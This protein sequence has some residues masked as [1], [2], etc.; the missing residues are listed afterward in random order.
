[1]TRESQVMELQH[2]V[3]QLEREN[4]RLQD[5]RTY[6]VERFVEVPPPDYRKLQIRCHE[7]SEEIHDL[8]N[9]CKI[10]EHVL[11]YGEIS[12]MPQIIREYKSMS[13]FY[14]QQLAK[15]IEFYRLSSCERSE[16]LNFLEYL[17]SV[18]RDVEEMLLVND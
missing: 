12:P 9:R 4:Q 7:A 16:L 17:H 14:L 8:Q 11:C 3:A 6:T 15:K 10:L 5:E 18:T 1:M 2:R 13:T